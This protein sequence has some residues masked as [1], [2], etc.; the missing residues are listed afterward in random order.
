[1]KMT[2][3]TKPFSIFFWGGGGGYGYHWRMYAVFVG[4]GMH[5]HI[6]SILQRIALRRP[7]KQWFILGLTQRSG[8]RYSGYRVLTDPFYVEVVT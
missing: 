3:T 2:T 7:L 1:M 8:H 6:L 5:F 4:Y